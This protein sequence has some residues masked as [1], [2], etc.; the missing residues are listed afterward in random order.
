MISWIVRLNFGK[1][2]AGRVAI[3][4]DDLVQPSRQTRH[5]DPDLSFTTLAARTDVYKYSRTIRD[6]NSLDT[7]SQSKLIPQPPVDI[8]CC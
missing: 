4:T 1:A 6:W 2:V 8:S 3:N 5:S 7:P